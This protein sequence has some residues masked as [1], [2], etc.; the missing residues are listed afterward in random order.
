MTPS[1]S[2]VGEPRARAPA[3]VALDD[4]DLALHADDR[5]PAAA[6]D[7]AQLGRDRLVRVRVADGEHGDLDARQPLGDP[8]RDLAKSPAA[9]HGAVCEVARGAVTR[10]D[11]EVRFAFA[12]RSAGRRLRLG[13]V[14]ERVD[15]RVIDNAR[16]APE[17]DVRALEAFHG[18][19]DHA[20][21]S[22]VYAVAVGEVERHD[23]ERA[24]RGAAVAMVADC[25]RDGVRNLRAQLAR[26][27]R[28]PL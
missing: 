8:G 12:A 7:L 18:I 13:L 9:D 1:S 19:F 3:L 10:D 20:H 11:D 17:L 16:L 21:E 27:L 22:A 15:A 4:V 25:A 23:D 24:G 28:L 5:R 14:D 6:R 26:L 2:P